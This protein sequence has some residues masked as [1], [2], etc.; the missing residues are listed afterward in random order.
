MEKKH[1]LSSFVDTDLQ[2]NDIMDFLPDATFVIDK[3]KRVIIWNRAMAELSGIPAADMLGK[4][5]DGYAFPFYNY[6]RPILIDFVTESDE[7]V[8]QYYPNFVRSR[9]AISAEM[10]VPSLKEGGAYLWAFAKPLYNPNGEVIGAIESFRDITDRKNDENI[11]LSQKHELE[12]I[13]QTLSTKVRELE[14]ANQ[15]YREINDRLEKAQKDYIE[16]NNRLRES[17]EKFASI[18]QLSPVSTALSKLEDG[19]FV[20]VN[21]YFCTV[22]GYSREE[23]IGH[24]SDGL[25]MWISPEGR[26]FIFAKLTQEGRMLN[27]EVQLRDKSGNILDMYFSAE[28]LKIGA[29]EY[30]LTM[31]SDITDHKKA[32][33]II[34]EQKEDLER[35]NRELKQTLQELMQKNV[36]LDVS[37]QE[38]VTANEKLRLS[39]EKFSKA[40]CLGPVIITISSV[41]DGRYVEVSD[42]FLRVTGY[43]RDEAIGRTAMELNVWNDEEDRKNIIEALQETG[44]VRDRPLQF[45]SKQGEIFL[46]LYSAEIISIGEV[47]HIVSVAVDITERQKAMEERERLKNQLRQA[48]KMESVGRLAGGVAHDFNNLL[49][50]IMGNTDM[51]MAVTEPGGKIQ[52][53]LEVI[54]KASES[55]ADLTRQLLAFSR[56]QVIEPQ[57]IDLND[58]IRYM[59][60]MLARMIGENIRLTTNI[61]ASVAKIMAD[62]GQIEQVI[63]NL[64]VN[65]RDAMPNGGKVILEVAETVFDI[66]YCNYH[67]YVLPGAYISLSVS[68]TGMGMENEIRKK[69]F[70]PFFTTKPMGKGTGLGLATV[71][72]AVKQNNGSIEVYSVPGQGTSFKIYFPKVSDHGE[73]LAIS[74]IH[75][76][77]RGGSETI[78][79]VED[80][81][82]VRDFAL[83][84]LRRLGYHVIEATSAEEAISVSGAF[85]KEIHLLLSDVILPGMNGKALADSITAIRPNIRVLFTSGY[86][87]DIIAHHGILE[88][89]IAFIEKPYTTYT[90]SRKIREV[91]SSVRK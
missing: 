27:E 48:Q 28:R 91:L 50:A 58:I 83:E 53:K 45:R 81:A 71:Y 51:A 73:M 25:N 79:L 62:P 60:K 87:G 17:E 69:I 34:R 47:P 64:V 82:L 49:T 1:P 37:R 46:M 33:E 57:V 84:A 11:I 59:S 35:I 89:G 54:M 4:D 63:V 67:P 41:A 12:E 19:C 86:T 7:V 13:N 39:E 31:S 36:Q 56:K 74:N 3:Q 21:D 5:N 24:S 20:D 29:N 10:F 65:A 2:L 55:A 6:R 70:E 88:E 26:G 16:A 80:D 78:L 72:G 68:D 32:R 75:D 22:S 23:I 40:F 14:Q 18:F 42:Y 30:L 76:V 15:E 77:V 43:A 52:S 85:D 9:D 44:V 66:A 90:L 38:L 8:R 61:H